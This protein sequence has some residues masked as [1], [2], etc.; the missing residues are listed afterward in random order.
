MIKHL[1]DN[2]IDRIKN[3][4]ENEISILKNWVNSLDDIINDLKL[5]KSIDIHFELDEWIFSINDNLSWETIFLEWKDFQTT[6][7]LWKY[8]YDKVLF[9]KEREKETLLKNLEKLNSF[10]WDINKYLEINIS[11]WTNEIPVLSY[12]F[13]KK[14]KYIEKIILKTN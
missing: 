7:N 4:I 2:E 14:Y 5:K 1:I 8:Q 10:I 12:N 3:I 6:F 9:K 11:F 13:D